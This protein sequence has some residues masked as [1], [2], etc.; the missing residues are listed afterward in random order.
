MF[1]I[2]RS[3]ISS[4]EGSRENSI[5]TSSE[6]SSGS[7]AS[8]PMPPGSIADT[9]GGKA[10]PIG[11]SNAKIRLYIR[12]TASRWRDMGS[13]RLTIMRPTSTDGLQ[14]PRPQARNEKRI[15]VNGKTKGEVLLDATLGESCFERVART[16]IAIS[17]W[18]DVKGPNGE[19]GVVNAVGGVGGGR[20]VV[21]M[22]QVRFR[23]PDFGFYS[24]KGT[25]AD[26]DKLQMKSEAET[27]Y[28]FSIV[29]K[30]RY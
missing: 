24:E 27:A 18:E 16:G 17:V 7:G 2:G 19:V 3:T 26:C 5:Y 25:V 4:R 12:E 8:S 30:L 23:F 10:A 22:V 15:V 11:I 28:T 1:N 13:A 9:N 29:G 20:A 6:N 14:P 21:Y